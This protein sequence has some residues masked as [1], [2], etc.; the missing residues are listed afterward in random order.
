M[1]RRGGQAAHVCLHEGHGFGVRNGH[2]YHRAGI[3]QGNFGRIS[4]AVPS[5]ERLP[6]VKG[7][8]RLRGPA[9]QRVGPE[10]A[11]EDESALPSG[12]PRRFHE[13]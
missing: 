5:R 11:R 6:V 13:E 8:V 10:T 1:V 9:P 2:P 3:S 12:I 7:P 4:A